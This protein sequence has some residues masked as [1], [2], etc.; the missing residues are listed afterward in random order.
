M[1]GPSALTLEHIT[2]SFGPV[3][4]LAGASL[5]V[6]RG[7]VHAVL[8][9]N[10]AGKSTLMRIA[11]GLLQPDGG[12]IL[13]DGVARR[14]ASS[15]DAI[16]S[17]L[18]MVHQHFTLVPTMTVAENVALGG[19]GRFDARAARRVVDLLTLDTGLVLD[20][21]ALAGALPVSAQ[22]RLEIL[23]ALAHRAHTL[24]LDEPTAVLSPVEADELL[25]WLR[26]FADDGGAAVLIT[27]K[28]REASAIADDVTVLRHGRTVLSGAIASLT[29][30]MLVH[31]MLGAQPEGDVPERDAAAGQHASR[32]VVLRADGVAVADDRGVTRLRDVTLELHRGEIVG[33][34]GVEGAGQREL[35]RVFA[36]R[37]PPSRGT[38][39]LPAHIGFVPG[40]RQHEA[41]A[42]DMSLSEN[43]ALRGAGARRG[44]MR[45]R[46]IDARTR[47][48][49]QRFDVRADSEARS[50]RSL[51]GG[52]QQRLVLA[53]ELDGDPPPGLLV[54]E[55]PVRGL[56]LR[57]MEDM[58]Q[59]LLAARDAG[60]CIVT[61]ASDLDEVLAIA[62]RLFVC[63]DG[64]LTE[65]AVDREAA[66]RAMVGAA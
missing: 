47:Q 63:F 14:H 30:P 37:L 40:D 42:L 58:L 46:A 62:D 15:A 52:N 24:I 55:N 35:L 33:I 26:R 6:R 36:G 54:A 31:A 16:R 38:L 50:A 56:D 61:Y 5:D 18:G 48:L 59:R 65:T 43:V 23:K 4:A 17:G 64:R 27:H 28:L 13:V 9:E 22:Q 51:S 49:M 2:K 3:R 10:G 11:F 41:L 12:R 25:A 19:R 39:R 8:G 57:A 32:D 44:W 34:A 21:S 45:W 53:R 66:G 29:E 7:T 1:N 20:P 60:M